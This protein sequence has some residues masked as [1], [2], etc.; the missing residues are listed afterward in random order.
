MFSLCWGLDDSQIAM[1]RR[2][3]RRPGTVSVFLW[4]DALIGGN[5]YVNSN[6]IS[7]LTDM[8]IR[9]VP[10]ER[11]WRMQ[12][13]QWFAKTMKVSSETPMGT[14]RYNEPCDSTADRD[15]YSPYYI[16][17]DPA[18]KPIAYYEG[19]RDVGIAMKNVGKST[20]I[21]CGTMNLVPELMRYCLNTSSA[22]QYTDTDNICYVNKSFVG[23]HTKQAGAVNVR[24]PRKQ[25]LYNVYDDLELGSSD[26]FGINTQAFKTYMSSVE[27]GNSG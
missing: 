25:T 24:L 14:L 1:I 2:V 13:S 10:K 15:A 21:F 7:R 6:L 8:N 18:A 12:P 17:D 20:V 26:N 19:T 9:V 16:I 11:S 3:T 23:L 5:G 27:H 4:G 22:F